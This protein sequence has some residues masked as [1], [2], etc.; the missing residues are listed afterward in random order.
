MSIP[1]WSVL[2][3]RGVQG[4]IGAVRLRLDHEMADRAFLAVSEGMDR[5]LPGLVQWWSNSSARGNRTLFS[6]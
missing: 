4:F 1:P 6:M 3:G 2:S 5:R